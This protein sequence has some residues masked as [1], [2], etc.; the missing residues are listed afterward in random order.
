MAM[1]EVD[2][3]AVYR[4]TCAS[5]R[6]TWFKSRQPPAMFCIHQMH[7]VNY[8]NSC[9]MMTASQ[10][11]SL[12]EQP[13]TVVCGCSY[14]LP[15]CFLKFHF[16]QPNLGRLLTDLAEIWHADRKL[17]SFTIASP[18]WGLGPQKNF[19]G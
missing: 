11:L 17:V 6:L 9:A 7:W 8:H 12:L 13:H 15:L 14:V 18:K 2:T 4:R 16:R 19:G 5:R 1:L 3:I 10:T